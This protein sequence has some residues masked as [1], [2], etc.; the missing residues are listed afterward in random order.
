VDLARDWEV[1]DMLQESIHVD[2]VE[3][4]LSSGRITNYSL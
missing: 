4:N 1:M 2:T 3:V